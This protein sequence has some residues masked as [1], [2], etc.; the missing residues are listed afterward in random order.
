MGFKGCQ[1]GVNASKLFLDFWNCREIVD[2]ST[3]K[4]RGRNDMKTLNDEGMK[5]GVTW[6]G[7]DW[8]WCHFVHS[9]FY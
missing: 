4:S 6:G 2:K 1:S 8:G 7:V 5:L 9:K 3:S